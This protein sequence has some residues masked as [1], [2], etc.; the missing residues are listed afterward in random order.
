MNG[1]ISVDLGGGGLE[2]FDLESL[3][4]SEH[5]YGA[6]DGSLDCLNGI[7]LIVNGRSGTG[8]V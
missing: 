8:E 3:R 2:N 1:R 6:M 4:K 5:I 7:K